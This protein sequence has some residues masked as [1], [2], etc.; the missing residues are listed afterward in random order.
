MSQRLIWLLLVAIIIFAAA[1][2]LHDLSS[3]PPSPYLDEVSNGYNAYSLLKTG[4]DEYGRHMPLLLQA[5]ND[6]RPALFVYTLIPFVATFGLTTFAIRLPAVILSVLTTLSIFFLTKFL[7]G[8]FSVIPGQSEEAH[9]QKHRI[10]S[11][12]KPQNDGGNYAEIIGLLAGFLFAISPWSIY[13]SHISD[14][15]N[16]SLSF[17][18]FAMTFFVLWRSKRHASSSKGRK[19]N[20]IFASDFL[21][22]V[23]I[24]FFVLA[25]YAYHGIKFFLPFFIIVLACLYWREL[26]SKKKTTII[27]FFLGIILLIPLALAFLA[28]GAL[29]RLGGVNNPH[30]ELLSLGSQR[31]LYDKTHADNVGAI[32]DNRRLLFSLEYFN[33]YLRNLDVTWLFLP[34]GN[35]TF[36]VPDVGPMY[37]FTLPLLLLGIYF[38]IRDRTI[39]GR[40]KL[41]L[42]L[43]ILL[44]PIPASLSSESPHLNRINTILPALTIVEA[45]GFFFLITLIVSL[46]S[47]D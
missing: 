22:L 42:L 39:S 7:F 19:N 45:V 31:V 28:P 17:F 23:S 29:N 16:M 36:L 12:A 18:V 37:L 24:V 8:G 1:I 25:F 15:I 46:R 3:V 30:P 38:L 27:G 2:R 34:Q 20:L 44:S 32:F 13:S 40:T 4:K 43:W 5:Y 41:L 10:D 14:E 47:L 11:S 9:S 21:L 33:D 26:W 35:V 6:F